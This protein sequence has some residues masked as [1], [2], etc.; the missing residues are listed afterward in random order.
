MTEIENNSTAGSLTN[1]SLAR[2]KDT[3]VDGID[4]VDP[5]ELMMVKVIYH[6]G[7]PLSQTTVTWIAFDN[8][9]MCQFQSVLSSDRIINLIR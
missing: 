3:G 2:F 9:N 7:P 6:S 1:G 4:N 8:P 5:D